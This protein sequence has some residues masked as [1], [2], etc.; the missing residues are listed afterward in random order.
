MD[1]SFRPLQIASSSGMVDVLRIF[2]PK[3]TEIDDPDHV[4]DTALHQ[5]AVG[6]YKESI[7]LLAGNGAEINRNNCRNRTPLHHAAAGCFLECVELM[8]DWPGIY[9]NTCDKNKRTPLFL[10]CSGHSP[11]TAC[12]ILNRLIESHFSVAEINQPTRRGRTLLG[13]SYARGFDKIVTKLVQYAK[14]HDEVDSLRVNETDIKNGLTSLHHAAS[15]GSVA[16]VNELLAVNADIVTKDKK[17]R[18]PLRIAC[19]VL[20]NDL[21]AMCAA[22]GSIRLLQQLHSL[23]SDLNRTDR[24]GWTPLDL[25]RKSGH[26]DAERLS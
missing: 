11:E 23:N 6:G 22:H 15:P 17:G 5:A 2:L 25:A 21:V 12:L 13:Q 4:G 7:Q 8:L 9:I 14:E 16:C 1:Y 3:V 10:A 24:Y 19:A 18:T 26:F 20:D